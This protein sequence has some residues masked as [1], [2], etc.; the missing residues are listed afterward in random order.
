[1]RYLILTFLISSLINL[2]L[3]LDASTNPTF[4]L[5]SNSLCQ[6]ECGSEE[7]PFS[8]FREAINTLSALKLDS[9]VLLVD[10][11]EYYG[12]DNQQINIDFNLEIRSKNPNYK[13]IIDCQSTSYA[14]KAI[15][16]TTL[17]IKGFIIKNC[18][19]FKGGA[20]YTENQ[21][22]TLENIIFMSN[23]AQLGSAVFSSAE[24]LDIKSCLFLSNLGSS[25]IIEI[26]QSFSK[27][28]N[29]RFVNNLVKDIQCGPMATR[30]DSTES[31]FTSSCS[32]ACEMYDQI[33]SG[34]LCN[35][36][37]TSGL[38]DCNLDGICDLFIET[39]EN[40]P[41]DCTA[42]QVLDQQFCNINGICEPT[43]GESFKN[44]PI[45][46][47]A[48]LVPGWKF[49]KFDYEISKPKQTFTNYS[50]PIEIDFLSF[51]S[52]IALIGK[53]KVLI[54]GKLSSKLS[55][56]ET[57]DY[58]FKLQT[59]NLAT[60]VYLD[61]RVLFDN[62]FK[63]NGDENQMTF[64]RKLLLSSEKPHFIEVYFTATN[65]FQR[66]LDLFWRTSS[67]DEFS[68]IPSSFISLIE[69]IECG[70]GICNEEPS[71]CLID[72]HDQFEPNCSPTSPALP[73]QSYY[74]PIQDTIGTLLNT[75][76]LSTLPGIKYMSQGIDLSTGKSKPTALFA[77]TYCDETSFSVVHFHYRDTVY[78]VPPGVNAQISP[79]CT[80]DS[81][82]K[83]FSSASAF[84]KNEAEKWGI[85]NNINGNYKAVTVAVSYGHSE[86]SKKANET[87]DNFDR[88]FYQ[89]TVLC[90][91]YKI[92]MVEPYRWNPRFIQDIG[93]AYYE[94][95][96]AQYAK[97]MTT[98]NMIKVIN[99]YGSGFYKSATL[100][101]KLEQ[102]TSIE[103]SYLQ[104]V[105]SYEIEKNNNYALAV[106]VSAGIFKGKA[107]QRGSIDKSTSQAQMEEYI[108][109]SKRSTLTVVGGAPGSY[110]EEEPNAFETWTNSLDK[111]PAP[112]EGAIGFV[113]DILPSSWYF[114]GGFNVK[115]IWEEAEQRIFKGLL[116][117]LKFKYTNPKDA[118]I[119]SLI[120]SL[121]KTQG[122]Y[123][124]IGCSFNSASKPVK[125]KIEN[126]AT[127]FGFTKDVL[128]ATP[129]DKSFSLFGLDLNDEQGLRSIQFIGSNG[130]PIVL[131][132]C[133]EFKLI[134]TLSTRQ[135]RMRPAGSKF[136]N[137]KPPPNELT[138]QFTDFKVDAPC[139]DFYCGGLKRTIFGSHGKYTDALISGTFAPTI[140]PK[141]LGDII[142]I[143][144]HFFGDAFDKFSIPKYY[145]Y[146]V[147]FK[148]VL[149]S[150]TCP[151]DMKFG[152]IPNK[153]ILD[154]QIGYT[155]TYETWRIPSRSELDHFQFVVNH[156]SSAYISIDPFGI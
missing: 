76:Y 151:D 65:D 137:S 95:E 88:N 148:S 155:K 56:T 13:T 49:E 147:S 92:N 37:I 104:K 1:M 124:L 102:L 120:N 75:Q 143:S 125:V 18:V 103:N 25:S 71:T 123:V 132:S 105:S 126:Q 14:F 106:S 61:G 17:L 131:S 20:I 32:S 63:T 73:L 127:P 6:S 9:I 117:Q 122:L 35:N 135:Y 121:G 149:I 43:L 156:T 113:S 133:D 67:Q 91:M 97:N 44:C 4:Y 60:I 2:I 38:S 30:V 112:I 7:K 3:G 136:V 52:I 129:A 74:Y 84:S 42:D 78:T 16:S 31:Y 109:N 99:N 79:Q 33:N 93:N 62:F 146:T 100:G 77:H 47:V 53:G 145:Q 150:Q 87:Q 50:N 27:I 24:V 128:F 94:H 80:S 86:N 107:S 101:G 10:Q 66:E 68:L 29:S 59:S 23:S 130:N 154:N 153:V 90:K 39:N 34:S 54:S 46:C 98:E 115:E 21:E 36:T 139:A 111:L 51:P 96:D 22:T 55:I 26:N 11:G 83:F 64:E 110:G 140:L 8:T 85:S 45:D 81:T 57:R 116:K 12:Q 5:S 142:G 134:S 119:D 89:S 114:K 48:E 69:K 15:G 141:Y 70:D 40:C 41:S 152:C 28:S 72:C 82:M 118:S 138:I 144:F 108:K 58:Y 19:A